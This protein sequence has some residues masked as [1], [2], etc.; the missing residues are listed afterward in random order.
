MCRMVRFVFVLLTVSIFSIHPR[1]ACAQDNQTVL[2]ES[3]VISGTQAIDST[4]L[5]EIANSIAGSIFR[6]DHDELEERLRAQFQE[7][8][9]LNAEVKNLEIKVID[10]LSNPKPVR[11]EADVSEGPR[12]RLSGIEFIDNHAFGSSELRA[13]FSI[14]AGDV[15]ARSKIGAGVESVKKL[16]GSRGYPWVTLIM[17]TR[18]DS[19]S[20][21]KLMITMEEGTQYRMGKLEVLGPAD[22]AARLQIRW[23]LAPGAI[24]DMGYPKMFLDKNR[25]LLPAD[26]NESTS[27]GRFFDCNDATVSIHLHLVQ[28]PEHTARDRANQVECKSDAERGKKAD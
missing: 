10:P 8:G 1:L 25:S 27:L 26:F 15:F 17:D 19:S 7:H 11:L 18:M 6:D 22:V 14:K 16:Y 13:K 5:A 23:K 20:T 3:L 9:Y 2:I 21:M 24:F 4:E 12:F 28:D